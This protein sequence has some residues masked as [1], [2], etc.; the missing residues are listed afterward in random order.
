VLGKGGLS[1]TEGLRATLNESSVNHTRMIEVRPVRSV[2]STAHASRCGSSTTDAQAHLRHADI[3]GRATG[4]ADL[5]ESFS[6]QRVVRGN[7]AQEKNRELLQ[8]ESEFEDR[9]SRIVQMY[10][11][12]LAQRLTR[13]LIR[14]AH[15]RSC[16][17][18]SPRHGRYS[19]GQKSLPASRAGS[20][21][22]SPSA[23]ARDSSTAGSKT[24]VRTAKPNPAGYP[25]AIGEG[26]SVP[27][28]RLS[29]RACAHERLRRVVLCLQ[30]VKREVSDLHSEIQRLQARIMQRLQH[31]PI[32]GSTPAAEVRRAQLTPCRMP[33]C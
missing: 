14:L 4:R 19:D 6:V 15:S 29:L 1:A 5:G 13:T 31:P 20:R 33:A 27:R 28:R 11:K 26:R 10:P 25:A 7:G 24:V 8:M 12:W 21:P 30:E 3:V 23:A 18:A 32:I 17:H 16:T 9:R 2:R 22:P